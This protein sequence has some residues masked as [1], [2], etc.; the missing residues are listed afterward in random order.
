MAELPRPTAIEEYVASER[1]TFVAALANSPDLSRVVREWL[2]G[3][4][5]RAIGDKSVVLNLTRNADGTVMGFAQASNGRIIGQARWEQVS[6][7]ST[8]FVSTGALLTGHLMLMQISEQLT[9]IEAKLDRVLIA[10]ADDRR[11]ELRGAIATVNNALKSRE[12]GNQRGLL[13]A[14]APLLTQAIRKERRALSRAVKDVP[15]PP[16]T[17][18]E[19]VFNNHSDPAKNHL[20]ECEDSL[21]AL[22]EGLRALSALYLAL[23]EPT[24]AFQQLDTEIEELLATVDLE[25]ARFKAR[26]IRPEKND[27]WPDQF[28]DRALSTLRHAQ[29]DARLEGPKLVL[30]GQVQPLMIQLSA[31]EVDRV[32][33]GG[34]M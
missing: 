24:L 18:M 29:L 27:I 26:L 3:D 23:G 17:R 4:L 12:V 1:A 10:L 32:A 2:S 20:K 28:W 22:I 31:S 5:Y 33:A 8:R 14:T 25:D 34:T 11:E 19:A 21:L 9:R 16:Q 13:Y 6:S 30:L 15:T 7:I